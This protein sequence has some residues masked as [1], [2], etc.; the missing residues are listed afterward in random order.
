MGWAPCGQET[1][2][3][4][5]R[6]YVSPSVSRHCK[7]RDLS[8][9]SH[10]HVTTSSSDDPYRQ[11]VPA[12][13]ATPNRDGDAETPR[14]REAA[15]WHGSRPQ[16]CEGCR[17]AARDAARPRGCEGCR[18]AARLRG[19]PRGRKAARLRGRPRGCDTARRR[20]GTPVRLGRKA[21]TLQAVSLLV[22]EAASAQ[23]RAGRAHVLRS[24]CECTVL[25]VCRVARLQVR[26][27]MGVDMPTHPYKE[28][29]CAGN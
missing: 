11:P 27:C 8:S 12:G 4:A 24:S 3:P 17:E 13:I 15:K 14:G 22:C 29:G 25:P 19:M 18:E 21:A 2:S 23:G 20:C 6:V 10:R 7:T 16:G 5:R 26:A 9:C 1:L 28:L